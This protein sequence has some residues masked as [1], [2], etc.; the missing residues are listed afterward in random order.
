MVESLIDSGSTHIGGSAATGDWNNLGNS[1][2]VAQCDS[3]QMPVH[4]T[5]AIMGTN[6]FIKG[7]NFR[8]SH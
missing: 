6:T 3:T 1:H 7:D 2:R 8:R 4:L 5:D